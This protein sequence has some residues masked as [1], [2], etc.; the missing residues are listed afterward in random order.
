MP[1]K[2]PVA[3]DF[4]CPWCWAGMLQA[5][6]LVAEEGIEIEWIGYELFPVELEWP[7]RAPEPPPPANKPTVLTRLE[8][9]LEADGID[10]PKLVKPYHM[11]SN[12]AH[13]ALEYAK[14][15]GRGFEF[16]EALYRAFWEEARNISE[17]D[18]LKQIAGQFGLD[19]DE[20]AIAVNE[21]RFADKIVHFDDAAYASGVYNV[22]TFFIGGERYAEQPYSVLQRAVRKAKA[23]GDVSVAPFRNLALPTSPATRPYTLIDMVATIDGKILS[24]ERDEPV[25][26]LGSD[27]D[28]AAMRNILSHVDAVLIGAGTL[29]STSPKWNPTTRIRVVVSGS[30]ELPYDHGFFQGGESYVATTEQSTFTPGN[31]ARLLRVGEERLDMKLL[32]QRLKEKGVERLLVLGGSETNAEILAADLA[33]ELFLTLAPKVK[34]GRDVPTYA[35]GNP[36][37]R[38]E[39]LGFELLEHHAVGS[40]LFLRYRRAN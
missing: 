25:T 39:L 22:P 18:E 20:L 8:F 17:V 28:H 14:A 35:D 10:L 12:N 3:H 32:M 38:N 1:L 15:N 2:I 40:E 37:P 11:R 36:L 27:V 6:R 16:C 24:G 9:L 23:G 21:K 34:L 7:E 33:D 13:Q 5:K 30:G 4:I 19:V 26:D 31:D 29:R